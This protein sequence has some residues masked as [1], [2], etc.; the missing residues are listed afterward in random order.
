M[1]PRPTVSVALCTHNG[2]A[3]LRSQLESILNQTRVPD[4][5]VI[6]DDASTDATLAVAAEVLGDRVNPSLI[7]L[8]NA[9]ALGVTSNFAQALAACSGDLL[10][11]CDQ[12]DV[13]D[14]TK[15]ERMIAEFEARPNL[16]LLHTDARIVGSTGQPT[17]ESLFGTLRVSIDEKRSV[18]G[19]D[20]YK[21][22]LRRNIVTGATAMLRRELFERAGSF[23][24][25]WVHDEWLAMVA[26][27]SGEM[28]LL[29]T[30][31]IDYRQ[32]GTNEIGVS[33][34]TLHTGFGRLRTSRSARNAR[35]FNRA[36][37]LAEW[38]ASPG[39][40]VPNQVS[41]RIIEKLEHERVRSA[42]PVGRARRLRPVLAEW[43]TGR[44]S[45]Y[46]LGLQDVLRDLV[47][48]A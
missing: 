10:T 47:Q 31:L 34:L 14:P 26:A 45:N 21:V 41:R 25:S 8:H 23:P 2:D 19:G 28:D 1:T 46:G 15:I 5:I 43:G 13:W 7:V 27:V 29:E 22:L 36:R 33:T 9:T 38:I 35:L 18:H 6:S 3:F 48:P 44:Y 30:S 16:L 17:G 40:E 42:L 37:S 32:H 20:A 12:D 24:S 39:F 11:L 4:E